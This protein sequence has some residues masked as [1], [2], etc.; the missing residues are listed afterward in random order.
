MDAEIGNLAAGIIIEPAEPIKAAIQVVSDFGC[1]AEP[2]IP[3]EARG[4]LAV[5]RIAD[6]FRPFV[7]DMESA[8]HRHF[9][10]AAVADEFRQFLTNR[11]GTPMNPNLADPVVFTNRSNHFAA[12]CHAQRERFL[13]VN[14]FAGF[15]GVNRLQRVPMVRRANDGRVDVFLFK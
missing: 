2:G 1:G 8:G 9:S 5:G 15:A 4:R 7:L 14:V 10:N 6:A 12:L 13:D 11:Y 3:I